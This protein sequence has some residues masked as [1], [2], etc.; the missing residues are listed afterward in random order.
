MNKDK[1][2]A[3]LYASLIGSPLVSL[4]SGIGTHNL[5][6]TSNIN[7]WISVIISYFIGLIHL[8]IFIYIFNYKEELN[9]SKKNTY[10]FKKPISNILNV[11]INLLIFIIGMIQLY[12]ISNFAISQFLSETP[13]LL[14]MIL[15]GILISYSVLTGINNISRIG[16]IFLIIITTLTIISTLGLIP[17]INISNLKPILENG[18]TPTL[19]GSI[20]LTITNITP[21]FLLLITPKKDITNNKNINKY[22]LLYYSLSFLFII[23]AIF[24]A[25]SSL[26]IYLCQV[27]QYPEYTVLKKISL[28]NFIER[29]EN[30]IYIKWILNSFLT[31]SL[32]VYHIST[33]TKENS[34]IAPIIITTLLITSTYIIFKSNTIFYYIGEHIFPYV[35]LFLLIIYIIIFINIFIRKRLAKQD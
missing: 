25:I 31:L 20:L 1:L 26:G 22:F 16:I 14:F 3:P 21:I 17:T 34:K 18:L 35:S 10:L 5:I 32:I 9:I 13:I 8:L 4:F 24:L 29:I 19:K 23:I 15:F 30:F 28:F 11:L 12:N 33:A 6:K 7:S 27:Y 2:T